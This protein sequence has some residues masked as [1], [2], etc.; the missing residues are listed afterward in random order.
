M[1]N[2]LEFQHLSRGEER[3]LLVHTH[4]AR[5]AVAGC[6]ILRLCNLRTNVLWCIRVNKPCFSSFVTDPFRRRWHLALLCALWQCIKTLYKPYVLRLVFS[7]Q[8]WRMGNEANSFCPG[9]ACWLT[10]ESRG[11]ECLSSD[12][13]YWCVFAVSF[14]H[15]HPSS[16]MPYIIWNEW[17]IKP[18]TAG[19]GRAGYAFSLPLIHF[20]PWKWLSLILACMRRERQHSTASGRTLLIATSFLM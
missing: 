14:W 9:I 12:S 17:G 11:G 2:A 18:N 7:A 19:T 13:K 3:L 10:S 15:I 16:L 5:L 8:W 4:C 20:C 1:V 6:F